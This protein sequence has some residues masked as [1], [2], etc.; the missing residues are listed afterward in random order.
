MTSAVSL[1]HIKPLISVLNYT[2]C[3]PLPNYKHLLFSFLF[4]SVAILSTFPSHFPAPCCSACQTPS[5]VPEASYCYDSWSTPVKSK[6]VKLHKILTPILHTLAF[7]K[8]LVAPNVTD[9]LVT[10]KYSQSVI[11][12]YP[13]TTQHSGNIPDIIKFYFIT[14][15]Y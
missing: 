6:T 15:L 2:I 11:Q 1:L 12:F 9:K 10:N 3:Q 14:L 13:A 7:Q 4:Q 8:R 5:L